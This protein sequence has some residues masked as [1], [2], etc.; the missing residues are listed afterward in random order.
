MYLSW[1]MIMRVLSEL[2]FAQGYYSLSRVIKVMIYPQTPTLLCVHLVRLD[3][4]FFFFL[5]K[6]LVC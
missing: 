1:S 3:F 2:S 6:H 5:R 4:F